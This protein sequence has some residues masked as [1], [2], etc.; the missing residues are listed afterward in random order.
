MSYRGK[1]YLFY[2]LYFSEMFTFHLQSLW[3]L[4]KL[5]NK[6]AYKIY[7]KWLNINTTFYLLSFFLAK[8]CE[9]LEWTF[10]VSGE[11]C[12]FPYK[13]VCY[14]FFK[15]YSKGVYS[16][17]VPIQRMKYW[18]LSCNIMI[19]KQKCFVHINPLKRNIC[20]SKFNRLLIIFHFSFSKYV[21]EEY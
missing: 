8:Q 18:L 10:S 7:F 17:W 3:M 9:S 2:M 6:V 20:L 14:F 5:G 15:I 13:I 1:Y 4:C 16:F 12:I 19:F 21:S 11:W